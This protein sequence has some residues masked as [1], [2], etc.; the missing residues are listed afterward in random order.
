MLARRTGRN[1]VKLL[2]WFLFQQP[3]LLSTVMVGQ[4]AEFAELPKSIVASI[5]PSILL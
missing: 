1:S 5:N 4:A 3:R 2:L